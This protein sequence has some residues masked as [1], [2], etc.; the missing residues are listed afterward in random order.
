MEKRVLKFDKY[1]ARICLILSI[2]SWLA[3]MASH[4]I[5][6]FGLRSSTPSGIPPYTPDLFLIG[7]TLL[8]YGFFRTKLLKA[9]TLNVIELLWRV[10]VTGLITTIISLLLELA[11]SFWEGIASNPFIAM[12]IYDLNTGLILCFLLST[13]AVLKKLVLYQKSKNLLRTWRFF[14][15]TLLFALGL[16]LF[17]LEPF[18][19]SFNLLLGLLVVLSLVLAGNLKWVAYLDFKEKWRSI[20]LLLLSLVY[21]LYFVGYLIE[22]GRAHV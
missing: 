5:V 6:I 16:V 4:Q 15:G 9:E 2:L 10:F 11:A 22:I 8:V 12:V 18:G 20:L 1:I 21:Q 19:A 3:M 17:N 14:E 13:F 7:Y